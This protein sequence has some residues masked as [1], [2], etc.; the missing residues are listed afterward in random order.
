MGSLYRS[1]HEFIF[2]YKQGNAPHV[3]NVELGRHGRN[4]TNVW[5]YPSANSLMRRVGGMLAQHPTPKPVAMVG[6]AI[7]DCS[8]Q[9][10][11]V[12]DPFGGSGSTL[13]AAEVTKRHARVMEIEPL[14]VDL[15]I[16]RWQRKTMQTATLAATG[17]SFEQ[18]AAERLVSTGK[19][20]AYA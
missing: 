18:V 10:N 15:M 2:V 5:N 14:Y 4:R 8:N 13:I 1:K 6:D 12:L 9:P 16:R 11:I 19:A 17:Q 3:N 7:R 20:V